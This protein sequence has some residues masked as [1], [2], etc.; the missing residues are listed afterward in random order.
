MDVSRRHVLIAAAALPAVAVAGRAAETV[1]RAA[2]GA[3]M[4]I[5]PVPRGTS[6]TCCAQCGAHDHGMLDP[7]CPLAPRVLG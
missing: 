2:N 7:R 5:R 4:A 1:V 3:I 6:G